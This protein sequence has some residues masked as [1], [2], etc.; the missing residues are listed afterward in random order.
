MID[1]DLASVLDRSPRVHYLDVLGCFIAADLSE[2]ALPLNDG[3]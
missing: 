2:E 3:S 1:E